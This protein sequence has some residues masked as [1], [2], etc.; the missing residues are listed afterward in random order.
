MDNTQ[1]QKTVQSFKITNIRQLDHEGM[2]TET[3]TPVTRQQIA[4][5]L[6]ETI[7]G[8]DIEQFQDYWA[9]NLEIDINIFDV[10]DQENI[11]KP[12]GYFANVYKVETDDQGMTHNG[13]CIADFDIELFTD[14]NGDH[15]LLECEN[16]GCIITIGE[17][18]SFTMADEP[19]VKGEGYFQDSVD[20]FWER[21]TPGTIVPFGEH[22]D[23]PELTITDAD[24]E[25]WCGC[26]HEFDYS[27]LEPK[28]TKPENIIEVPEP[29]IMSAI[30]NL[31]ELSNGDIFYDPSF[32]DEGTIEALSE[33]KSAL[34]ELE[35]A[36]HG[37]EPVKQAEPE[38]IKV[39]VSISQGEL[40]DAYTTYAN[41]GKV[42]V[43]VWDWDN[44]GQA[45]RKDEANEAWGL[46]PWSPETIKK[47]HC[48]F[49]YERQ[50]CES[51]WETWP[52]YATVMFRGT[53]FPFTE[54][55]GNRIGCDSLNA[56]LHDK[57]GNPVNEEADDIDEQFGYY[58]PF[59]VMMQGDKA[60]YDHI[61]AEI[62][63]QFPGE[64]PA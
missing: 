30:A 42:E 35:R 18:Q 38:P 52:E 45:D 50:S 6:S 31:L 22:F 27:K 58:I 14:R 59:E 17:V 57:D 24:Q 63:D 43:E 49:E 3:E 29:S 1:T 5:V 7:L 2:V 47:A 54:V 34:A 53:R 56:I 51:A 9:G 15:V 46:I 11:D 60:V 10:T 28:I 37:I 20:D 32:G 40:F 16:C 19:E 13:D 21:M 25:N 61:K 33:Y 64:Q 48:K 4:K 55:N 23:N 12:R 26:L 8:V 39:W 36:M 41:S 62:D 44:I